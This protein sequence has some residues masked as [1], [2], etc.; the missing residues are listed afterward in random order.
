MIKPLTKIWL[1]LFLVSCLLWLFIIGL[2]LIGY[3][4]RGY[5]T[6]LIC[7]ISFLVLLFLTNVFADRLDRLDRHESILFERQ[8]RGWQI[9]I[10]HCLAIISVLASTVTILS[11]LVYQ[12]SGFASGNCIQES[13]S[14]SGQSIVIKSCGLT[15]YYTLHHNY[16]IFTEVE[17]F[18]E[19]EP[20]ITGKCLGDRF[21]NL[22]INWNESETAISWEITD[23]RTT[24]YHSDNIFPYGEG[25]SISPV[26]GII[27]IN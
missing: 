25:N 22:K 26:R 9:N 3:G 7:A 5:Y 10:F 16:F 27:S 8:F 23:Y 2:R 11:F 13:T 20:K 14:P 6:N 15:C 4:L 12:L 18:A 19:I 21:A 24:S 1:N 17:P